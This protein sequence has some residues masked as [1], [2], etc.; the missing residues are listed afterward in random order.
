[1][2]KV[3]F[4]I[5][6]DDILDLSKILLFSILGVLPTVYNVFYEKFG[7]NLDYGFE[8]I[9]G[10]FL[11][12][13]WLKKY[14]INQGIK[15]SFTDL[16]RDFILAFFISMFFTEVVKKLFPALLEN[17]S[18]NSLYYTTLI[19]IGCGAFYE[20]IIKKIVKKADSLEKSDEDDEKKK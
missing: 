4:D 7:M 11:M 2:K 8:G 1:M 3:I 18:E 13:L 14:K 12:W 19:A 15:P 16:I 5:F 17:S 10:Q 9:L 6:E 20:K